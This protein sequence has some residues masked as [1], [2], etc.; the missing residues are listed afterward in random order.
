MR[1]LAVIP[2]RYHSKRLPGKPLAEIGGR[3][4]IE[5]VYLRVKQARLVDRVVVATDDSRILDKV[6]AFGGEC[7]MTS[8]AH[9]SGTDR[10]AEAAEG[11]D[12]ELIV[13][14][15]GD[16]PLLEPRA[17]DQAIAAC[18]E[19]G[20]SGRSIGSL[21]KVITSADELWDPNV[22][23]VVTDRRGYALYFSRFP[24]PFVA[25]QDMGLGEL[26]KRLE[27]RLPPADAT[28]YKHIGLYVYP[29]SILLELSRLEP[30]PLERLEKLEQLR[31]LEHGIPIRMALTDYETVAVDTPADL[32]R[33]RRMV[34]VL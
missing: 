27:R 26:R 19:T 22:V 16:E 13:N 5:H 8:P 23:K 3:P 30:T 2:A 32:D 28:C 21:R 29:K 34:D 31:A 18:H 24:V 11:L 6:L 15:Q 9:P 33:V 1:T 20:E 25:S 14:V 10:V 17:I 4:M 7:F 12:F